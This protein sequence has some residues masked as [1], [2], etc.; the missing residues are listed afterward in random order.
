MKK[1]WENGKKKLS[2]GPDF[3]FFFSKIS[4]RHSLDVSYHHVQFQKTLMIQS[5]EK[6]VTDGQTLSTNA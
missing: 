1:I 2:F 3:F 6:L 5:W 4:L